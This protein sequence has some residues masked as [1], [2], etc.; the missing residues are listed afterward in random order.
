MANIEELINYTL[1]LFPDEIDISDGELRS[2]SGFF[3]QELSK[4][5]QGAEDKILL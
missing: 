1:K 4:T 2:D 3:S 5:W